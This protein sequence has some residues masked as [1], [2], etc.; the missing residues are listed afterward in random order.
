MD[1]A[2]FDD[3][4]YYCTNEW[5]RKGVVDVELEGSFGV[6]VAVVWDDVEESAD[7]IER[8]ASYVG[9]LED[10]A[11]T[12]TD[13]LCSGVYAFLLVLDEDGYFSGA[14]RLEN[15]GQLGDGL[16]ENVRRT[17]VDLGYANHDWDIEGQGD[18][19]MLL[20]HADQAI[21][22]SDHE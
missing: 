19:Q 9:D 16:L 2:G 12:L 6:I 17:D 14:G 15:L 18:A 22:G 1:D 8:M 20:T 10:W 7:E 13:E 4:R 11:D 21:V 5:Y 3:T